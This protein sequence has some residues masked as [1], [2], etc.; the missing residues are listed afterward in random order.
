[1]NRRTDGYEY[2]FFFCDCVSDVRNLYYILLVTHHIKIVGQ[3]QKITVKTYKS[4]LLVL[5]IT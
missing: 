1:V 3:T 4:R 5:T 2:F